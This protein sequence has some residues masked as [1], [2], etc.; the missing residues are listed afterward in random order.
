ME[1]TTLQRADTFID[2][3]QEFRAL[4]LGIVSKLVI[5]DAPELPFFFLGQF[6]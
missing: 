1:H 3:S 4:F 5:E 6:R 2:S